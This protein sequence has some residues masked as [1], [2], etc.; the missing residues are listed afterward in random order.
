MRLYLDSS[1]V[2]RCVDGTA[3]ER[4][5]S[6]GWIKKAANSPTGTILVSKL[7]RAECLVMPY[8]NR[9]NALVERFESVFRE[10]GIVLVSISDEILELATRIF[11]DYGVKMA[12]AIHTATAV[13]GQCDALVAKDEPW[14]KKGSILGLRLIA[15]SDHS[16]ADNL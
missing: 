11:A 6:I 16:A 15:F 2:R 3:S 12:D 7:V 14:T 8:R 13:L 4:Q 1:V 5:T 10:N 9:D